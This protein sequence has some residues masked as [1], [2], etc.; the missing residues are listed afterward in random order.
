MGGGEGAKA[1]WPGVG[2]RLSRSLSSR[3]LRDR[4]QTRSPWGQAR[5]RVSSPRLPGKPR[6]KGEEVQDLEWKVGMKLYISLGGKGR[7]GRG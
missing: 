1:K 4:H 2:Q 5:S 3:C 7:A 6:G